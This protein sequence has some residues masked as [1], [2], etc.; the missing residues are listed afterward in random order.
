[1]T[2]VPRFPRE[3]QDLRVVVTTAPPDVAHDLAAVLVRESLAACVQL[4][5]GV[6]SVYRW[7]GAVH[8]DP[9]TLLVIKTREG[10]LEALGARIRALHPYEVPELVVLRPEAADA[11]Y[12]AW[13]QSVTAGD[14]P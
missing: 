10:L 5:P 14:V 1:M 6:R 12:V 4:L 7:E 3:P 2:E 13:L 8:D 11:S 9:E